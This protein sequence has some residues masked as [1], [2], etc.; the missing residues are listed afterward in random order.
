[1][2][3]DIIESTHLHLK[4]QLIKS[5]PY[6]DVEF[7]GIFPVLYISLY[8]SF[9]IHFQL[10]NCNSLFDTEKHKPHPLASISPSTEIANGDLIRVSWTRCTL[11]MEF[12]SKSGAYGNEEHYQEYTT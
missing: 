7:I 2:H 3:E 12:H 6:I 11:K 4:L 1:M 5:F 9:S 8:N 10:E